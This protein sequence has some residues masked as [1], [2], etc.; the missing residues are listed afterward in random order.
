MWVK[1]ITFYTKSCIISKVFSVCRKF[2]VTFHKI[3]DKTSIIECECLH[4]KYNNI[5]NQQLMSEHYFSR[6]QVWTHNYIT[7]Y[8]TINTI[9]VL[10]MIAFQDW[11]GL[12]CTYL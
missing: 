6:G 2:H 9:I 4:F 7:F 10:A 5:E 1:K 12:Y 8:N 3:Y 11:R